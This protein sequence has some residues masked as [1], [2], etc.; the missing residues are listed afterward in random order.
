[1]VSSNQSLLRLALDFSL[2]NVLLFSS[3]HDVLARPTRS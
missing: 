3:S 2:P 1:M